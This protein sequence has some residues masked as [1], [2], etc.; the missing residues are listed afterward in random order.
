VHNGHDDPSTAGNGGTTPSEREQVE[1][2]LQQ[3]SQDRKDFVE[4]LTERDDKIDELTTLLRQARDDIQVRHEA[5][6]NAWTELTALR[7]EKD[8]AVNAC[9]DA[10]RRA[11]P[12]LPPDLIRGETLEELSASVQSAATLVEKVRAALESEK[13]AARVPAG[14][15][16][17][18]GPDLGGLSPREKIAAGVTRTK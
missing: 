14:A 18:S 1:I 11:H 10:L 2:Q 7:Q 5:A 8:E 17:D 9:R 15:P 4:A 13:Q 6:D 12:E 3:E 16:V